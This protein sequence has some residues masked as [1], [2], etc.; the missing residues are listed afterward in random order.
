VSTDVDGVY[1]QV[2]Y[3]IG[4]ACGNAVVR[5]NLRR[6]MRVASRAV[7]PE[8]PKGLY[9]LR[10]EPAA[11]SRSVTELASDVGRA[12]QRAAGPSVAS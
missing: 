2:G 3:A 1:P 7:A 9:L 5:N 12:L 10:A 8:L 11:A 4:K 6:R